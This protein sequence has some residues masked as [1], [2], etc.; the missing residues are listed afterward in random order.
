MWYYT[1]TDVF[2]Y[3]VGFSMKV[4][5][6]S[7]A[8]VLFAVLVHIGMCFVYN[9]TYYSPAFDFENRYNGVFYWI[10]LIST[11]LASLL[12]YYI[13]GR[14]RK[15]K[16]NKNF[17]LVTLLLANVVLLIIGMVSLFKPD[18]AETYQFINGPIY[19]YF[20]LVKDATLY[21]TIPVMIATALFPVFF[22]K[23]GYTKK[24]RTNNEI[25]M[26]DIEIKEEK[27]L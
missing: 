2:Y 5:R 8:S 18:T 27:E 10:V 12:L 9:H 14:L 13:A 6:Q 15:D 17:V 16:G 1:L 26:E 20:L 23:L 19:M 11:Y 7:L 22:F 25:K 3:E 24:P 4:I 21:I